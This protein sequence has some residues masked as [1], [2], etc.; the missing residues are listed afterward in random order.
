MDSGLYGWLWSVLA[1]GCRTRGRLRLSKP[2]ERV[3]G[4]W[5][6]SESKGRIFDLGQFWVHCVEQSWKLGFL[7]F[8]FFGGQEKV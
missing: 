3:A 7:F 6:S 5:L 1:Y 4:L 8:F 2:T